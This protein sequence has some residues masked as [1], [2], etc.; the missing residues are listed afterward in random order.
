[1]TNEVKRANDCYQ[2]ALKIYQ[3]IGVRSAAPPE[4]RLGEANTLKA[5]GDVLQFQKT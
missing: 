1:M 3:E 4:H 5:I 2:Q